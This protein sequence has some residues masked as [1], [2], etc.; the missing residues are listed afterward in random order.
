MQVAIRRDSGCTKGEEE[1]LKCEVQG[2]GGP[3]CR[4]DQQFKAGRRRSVAETNARGQE[5]AKWEVF[6]C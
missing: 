4:K 5:V 1:K 3:V 2:Q 6:M